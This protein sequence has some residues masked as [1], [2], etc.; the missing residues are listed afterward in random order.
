MIKSTAKS[1]GVMIR[2]FDIGMA[3]T[4]QNFYFGQMCSILVW[5]MR[6]QNADK[7]NLK[8]GLI[9]QETDTNY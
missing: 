3:D 8:D 9:K 1:L 5:S 4:N 2:K 6:F 7:S